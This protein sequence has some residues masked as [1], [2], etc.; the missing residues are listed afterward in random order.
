MNV[1]RVV[2]QQLYHIYHELI[3]VK[4]HAKN[5]SYYMLQEVEKQFS[6]FPY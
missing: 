2:V 3:I 4:V 6:D 5:L 1:T